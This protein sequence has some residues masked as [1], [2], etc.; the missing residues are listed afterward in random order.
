L[1]EPLEVIVTLATD[2][3]NRVKDQTTI[4]DFFR[5][6]SHIFSRPLSELSA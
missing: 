3:F 4:D 6:K 2:M 5:Y 1:D